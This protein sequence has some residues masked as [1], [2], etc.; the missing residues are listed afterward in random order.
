MS[1]RNKGIYS[2]LSNTFFYSTVQRVMFATDFR[3]YIGKVLKNV[4]KEPPYFIDYIKLNGSQKINN[5]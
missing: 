2:L 5:N 1:Q 4:N 3:E